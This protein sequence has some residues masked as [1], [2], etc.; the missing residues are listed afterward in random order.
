MFIGIVPDQEQAET[1]HGN[2][3]GSGT[4]NRVKQK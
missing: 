2:I 1:W 3:N 4:Q